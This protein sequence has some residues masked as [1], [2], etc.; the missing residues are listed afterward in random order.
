MRVTLFTISDA[1]KVIGV[2]ERVLRAA[3][4]HGDGPPLA[5]LGPRWNRIEANALVAWA[6]GK[7]KQLPAIV[8]QYE[9]EPAKG[10][11][12]NKATEGTNE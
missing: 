8:I 10:A 5:H 2:S 1:A 9:K 11:T 12:G 7:P 6:Q 3:I 4:K